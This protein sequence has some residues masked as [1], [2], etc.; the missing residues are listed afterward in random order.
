MLSAEAVKIMSQLK[1]LKAFS[2]SVFK[3]SVTYVSP[4]NL[5]SNKLKVKDGN[6]EIQGEKIPLQ[7][8]FYVV[9]FG[10]AV[11][12]MARS[13]EAILGSHLRTGIL[14]IPDGTIESEPPQKSPLNVYQGAA[15]NLP[16]SKSEKTSKLIAELIAPL[17]ADD[18]LLVLISG[19]GSALLP[20]PIP[21][22]T[23]EDKKLITEQLAKKGANIFEL[24]AVRKHLSMLKGG[25]LARLAYPSRVVSLILSDVIN[26][27]LDIIASGP[28]VANDNP[29]SDAME[30][31]KKY[32]LLENAP[33]SV[34][35]VLK[36]KFSKDSSDLF[37]HTSNFIIGS[38]R[39]ALNAG[40]DLVKQSGDQCYI[41]S[42]CIEGL[43]SDVATALAQLST[44]ICKIL[45]R[46][47]STQIF[48]QETDK[49]KKTL[50]IDDVAMKQFTKSVTTS[51]LDKIV[52]MFGGET[53]VAVTGGGKGGRNQEL[54]LRFSS[55]I[56]QISLQEPVNR[57]FNVVLL[58]CGT[59]GIDGPTDAA[60][61]IGYIGQT[62]IA[63]ENNLSVEKFISENDSYNFYS[64]LNQGEDLVKVGHTGTNVMDMMIMV[65]QSK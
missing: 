46:T 54:A 25:K 36:N 49:L 15:N 11:L 59:D 28:T 41:M 56:D 52:L 50:C 39:I 31:L 1:E 60:G 23:L 10:K 62:E 7:H 30:I 21:P 57:L 3:H 32:S 61:A 22:V 51:S 64:T 17:G 47:I 40:C 37:K 18:V 6:L 34:I 16:D 14:S 8:N 53:T 13:T 19:G 63:K 26:D 45:A 42:C 5:I 9:G 48:I 29:P 38:N 58:S 33:P 4:K 2:K 65:V 55:A 24:N 20:Y 43:V 35:E 12:E 27:R 44:L